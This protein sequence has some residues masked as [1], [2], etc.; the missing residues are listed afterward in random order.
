MRALGTIVTCLLFGSSLLA[1][2][3]HGSIPVLFF[4][5]EGHAPDR[6]KYL[7]RTPRMNARFSDQK[8]EFIVGRDVI[9]LEFP[10][11]CPDVRVESDG[12]L[13]ARANFLVGDSPEQWRH[14][15]GPG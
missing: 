4:A 3:G 10:D 13:T 7:A 11:A 15:C 12:L 2:D 1:A 8:A 6:V 5:N 14:E 9:S